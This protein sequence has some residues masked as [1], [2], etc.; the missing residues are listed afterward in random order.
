MK[1]KSSNRNLQEQLKKEKETSASLQEQLEVRERRERGGGDLCTGSSDGCE[2]C[3][4][5]RRERQ[6]QPTRT[7]TWRADLLILREG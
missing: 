6:S 1:E 5:L 3:R 4:L 2:L 7:E